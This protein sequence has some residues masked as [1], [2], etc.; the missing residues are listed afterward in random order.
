MLRRIFMTSIGLI[1]LFLNSI[2]SKA[3]DTPTGAD[4]LARQILETELEMQ[5]LN[6]FLHLEAA[7]PSFARSRRTWLWDIGNGISTESGLISA[8]TIFWDHTH[9]KTVYQKSANIENGRLEI[10]TSSTHKHN[11]VSGSSIAGTLYP[12]IIGQ[13]IGGTGSI[14]ELGF[15]LKRSARIDQKQLDERTLLEKMTALNAQSNALLEELKMT[16]GASQ[17]EVNLLAEFK[18][19]ILHEFARLEGESGNLSTGQ[20]VE[21]SFS[22]VRNTVGLIGNSINA[23]AVFNNNK[24][25]NGTGNILNLL[26]ATMIT[27]RPVITNASALIERKRLKKKIQ[28]SFPELSNWRASTVEH[29]Q[30]VLKGK[31]VDAALE[32]R[33]LWYTEQLLK[34][35]DDRSLARD[36]EAISRQMVVRR[37]RETIYGPTKISQSILGLVIGFQNGDNATRDNRMAAAG[38]TAYMTGQAFN[39]IELTRERFHDELVHAKLKR[40]LLLPQDRIKKQLSAVDQLK[41]EIAQK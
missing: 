26:A 2:S 39:I 4:V 36:E 32:Q 16:E 12:Q 17:A 5:K 19:E 41:K 28:K 7:N 3:T 34:F 15:D 11:H 21:D 27:V 29:E 35:E 10:K 8:A 20:F 14:I 33:Q 31:P 18:L 37:Y 30:A 6:A 24:K 22:L 9:D 13:A 1:F 38:N 23:K 40:F 25:I